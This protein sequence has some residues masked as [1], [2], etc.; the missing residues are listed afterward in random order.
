MLVVCRRA[1]PHVDF[2]LDYSPV[3]LDVPPDPS[4]D[5][6]RGTDVKEREQVGVTLGGERDDGKAIGQQVDHLWSP[7]LDELAD[8][9]WCSQERG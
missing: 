6:V 5:G 9:L 2:A 8:A 3:S 7:F 4:G 1:V